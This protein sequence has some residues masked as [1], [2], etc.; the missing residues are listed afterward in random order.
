LNFAVL[1]VGA[2]DDDPPAHHSAE[3]TDPSCIR[4]EPVTGAIVL[5]TENDMKKWFAGVLAVAGMWL[6]CVTMVQ[7]Q[8]GAPPP[9]ATD[10]EQHRISDQ[11]IA[12]MRQD[13]RSK[14]KQ[15]IAQNLK[16]TDAEATKFWPI[17]DQYTAE[18]VKINDKKYAVIQEYADRYGTL[19]DEHATKLARQWMEVDVA[20]AQLRAKYLPIVSQAIGG[21]KGATFAQ[22]DRR[23]SL[24]VELQ[25]AS[26]IPLVQSQ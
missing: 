10:K 20:A 16:L 23:V 5:T 18:L 6:A 13:I 22:L 21:R 7:A 9:V 8:T 4:D 15:L 11:D 2:V 19:T 25:L 3:L 12:L 1:P 17:Y 14:K 24:M 26:Q